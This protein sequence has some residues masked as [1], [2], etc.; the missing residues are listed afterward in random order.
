[1]TA[2]ID[3]RHIPVTWLTH[4]SLDI[5]LQTKQNE[6]MWELEHTMCTSS[7]C[8]PQHC[9]RPVF[10]KLGSARPQD[11]KE[12]TLGSEINTGINTQ[13][14]GTTTKKKYKYTP[15]DRENI[16]PATRYIGVISVR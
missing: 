12:H 14:F 10:R 9:V 7:L 4:R 8:A 11:S 3:R 13:L 1:M 6:I 16:C 5:W 2:R 15:K